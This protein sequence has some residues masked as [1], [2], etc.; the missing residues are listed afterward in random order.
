MR[1]DAGE[2]GTSALYV[3]G[4]QLTKLS[5]LDLRLEGMLLEKNGQQ[6]SIGAMPYAG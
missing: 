6:A 2:A 1:L 4:K 5:A 3:L